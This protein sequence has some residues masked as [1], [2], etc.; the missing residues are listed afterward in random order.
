MRNKRGR[1]TVLFYLYG[2]MK[3]VLRKIRAIL[4]GRKD[5]GFVYILFLTE[6]LAKDNKLRVLFFLHFCE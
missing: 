1:E 4:K 3:Y 2:I 6:K 5:Y